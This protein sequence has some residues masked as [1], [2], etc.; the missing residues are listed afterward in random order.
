MNH[1]LR[2]LSSLFL[3]LAVHM[4]CEA[5]LSRKH[6]KTILYSVLGTG[7][8]AITAAGAAYVYA[9][10]GSKSK[11][12]VRIPILDLPPIREVGDGNVPKTPRKPELLDLLQSPSS[13]AQTTPASGTSPSF[14]LSPDTSGDS[15]MYSPHT[16]SDFNRTDTPKHTT[17]KANT[18]AR[19]PRTP[20]R[21]GTT[22]YNDAGVL[23]REQI[24]YSGEGMP[25]AHVGA[26]PNKRRP[27]M[28][29]IKLSPRYKRQ[30]FGKSPKHN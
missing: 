20:F 27:G 18:N 8:V 1:I 29:R 10:H 23:V 19:P 3:M 24:K 15:L 11:N 9:T 6:Q 7:L 28:P 14:F 26:T 21:R 2:G 30:L 12:K 25:A 17:P 4:P 16:P 22:S 5:K 13:L